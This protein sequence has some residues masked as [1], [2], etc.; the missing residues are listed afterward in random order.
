MAADHE[1]FMDIAIAESRTAEAEGNSPVGSVIV[2]D[3][4]VIGVGRNRVNSD[5]DPTAHAEIDAIRDACRKLETSE[6]EGALCYTSMEPCPMCCWAIQAAGMAGIVMGG[7][8]ADLKDVNNRDY[9]G[10]RVETLMTLTGATL[11]IVTGV[12][13]REC[14]AMRREWLEK[15]GSGT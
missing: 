13:D 2:R 10:Y 3:G 15:Q 14:A 12:K 6:L 9:G 7:R 5:H 1:H 8:I 4:A 11:D